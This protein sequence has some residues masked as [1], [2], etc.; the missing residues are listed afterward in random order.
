[1]EKHWYVWHTTK[2]QCLKVLPNEIYFKL[3]FTEVSL[4]HWIMRDGYWD[5]DQQTVYLCTECFRFEEVRFL[6]QT[7]RNMFGFEAGL[8]RRLLKEGVGYRIRLSRKKANLTKL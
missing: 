3:Y 1:M 4:A 5:N 7:M 8:K 6:V 2:S